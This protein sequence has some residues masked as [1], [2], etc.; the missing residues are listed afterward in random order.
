MTLCDLFD[1]AWRL[2]VC[3]CVFWRSDAGSVDV[4]SES[5]RLL[6]RFK[7]VVAWALLVRGS[8]RCPEA[9]L[10]ALSLM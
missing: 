8:V 3:D 2:R 10:G 4:R 5:E 9:A 6:S 1:N 7:Y